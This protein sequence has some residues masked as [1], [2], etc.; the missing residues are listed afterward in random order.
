MPSHHYR[1]HESTTKQGVLKSKNRL[2][3]SWE[4]YILDFLFY[5]RPL[6]VGLQLE[7]TFVRGILNNF[8]GQLKHTKVEDKL[9]GGGLKRKHVLSFN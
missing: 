7:E 6:R 8:L 1:S 9:N 4:K 5:I 3:P 2:G